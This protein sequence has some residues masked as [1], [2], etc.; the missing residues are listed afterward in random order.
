M[1]SLGL[2]IGLLRLGVVE[3]FLLLCGKNCL[4]VQAVF[5]FCVVYG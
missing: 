4:D 5:N 2:S 1:L 3:L